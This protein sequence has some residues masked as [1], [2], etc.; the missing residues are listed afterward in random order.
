MRAKLSTFDLVFIDREIFDNESTEMEERFREACGKMV[1][2][3]D[4]AVFLRYPE[5]FDHLMKMADLVVCGNRF[6]MERVHPLNSQLLHIPTCV[7]MED[8]RQRRPKPVS[9][10]P[11]VGWMGTTG[12]LKYL[13]VPANALRAVAAKIP[14]ELRVVV[15]D[16]S[17]L[18]ETNLAGV[19]LVHQR[20][21]P[22]G[23]VQQLQQMDIGL[24][25][26]FANQEWDIYKCG[27]KLIQYLAVGVP[28]IAAPVGVNS[29]IM[30]SQQNGLTAETT[31][32]WEAALTKLL[33]N[34]SMRNEMGLRGRQT[35]QAK[36]SIGANYPVLRDR[37]IE[38][39]E[40][41]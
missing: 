3:I 26:L 14:Y 18:A 9:D 12:N 16:I 19:N 24:M 28:A 13:E 8:Y 37:L 2:D 11:V 34:Q 27:L 32:E 7:D 15:P 6:L 39:V 10:L 40:T 41:H 38:L 5:K 20:W 25:P 21:D 1:I 31:D 29:E 22:A 4:D 30:E 17:P 23:E 33:S 36:Y 35:V